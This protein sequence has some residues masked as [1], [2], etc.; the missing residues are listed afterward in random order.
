MTKHDFARNSPSESPINFG[1]SPPYN[2]THASCNYGKVRRFTYDNNIFCDCI[3]IKIQQYC[4]HPVAVSQLKLTVYLFEAQV[5]K[6]HTGQA[7][8]K[9][10]SARV[11]RKKHTSSGF[12]VSRNLSTGDYS[13]V[14]RSVCSATKWPGSR[15]IGFSLIEEKRQLGRCWDPTTLD[16]VERTAGI[17]GRHQP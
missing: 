9:A 10:Q 16:P 12:R 8:T 15:R 11:L 3:S 7:Q 4:V 2:G 14:A 5:K 17:S 13:I 1:G 6:A